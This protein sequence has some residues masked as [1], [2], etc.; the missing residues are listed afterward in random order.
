LRGF[1]Q[2]TEI[3]L[4]SV[5]TFVEIRNERMIKWVFDAAHPTATLEAQIDPCD[6]TGLDPGDTATV[7][8][9]GTL[10]LN[11]KA[12]PV[13]ADMFVTRL[14]EN[15]VMITTDEMIMLS[16]ADA[17]TDSGISKLMALAN[18]PGITRVSPVSLRFVFT[19]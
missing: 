11:G 7:T 16:M 3:D 5:E 10:T 8:I 19:K 9:D 1:N 14:S 4:S 15:K 17:G 13:E 12:L 6:V 18:L 2:R